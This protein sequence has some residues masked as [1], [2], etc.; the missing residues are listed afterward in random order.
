MPPPAPF[1]F[2][3]LN[4]DLSTVENE[5]FKLLVTTQGDVRPDVVQIDISGQTYFL[6]KEPNGQ[7]SFLFTQP[8]KDQQFRLVSAN[9]TSDDLILSVVKAPQIIAQELILNY[10][11][12]T[13]LKTKR[14][15][16]LSNLIVPEGTTVNWNIKT[17]S[18]ASVAFQDEASTIFLNKRGDLFV[19]SK[20]I[21]SRLDYTLT[22]SNSQLKNYEVLESQID[23]IPDT[24][25]PQLMLNLKRKI[26]QSHRYIFTAK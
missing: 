5:S 26:L 19:Y 17:A 4:D 22:T 12:Y 14:I 16:S 25:P 6:N 15:T 7:F 10:P 11:F 9:V 13:G 1:V 2:N 23:I 20:R 21:F 8:Q 24:P 3:I 18:T